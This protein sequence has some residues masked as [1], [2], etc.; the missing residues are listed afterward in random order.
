[1][2]DHSAEFRRCL[3]DLDIEGMRRLWRHTSSHLPQPKNDADA[4][5]ALH[6]ARTQAK[7]V[8]FKLRAYSH[9]W[10]TERGLPSQLPDNLRPKAERM[11]PV[12]VDAVGIS[13]NAKSELLLPIVPHIRAA[14]ENVVLDAYA[15]GDKDPSI[16]K[17][18]MNEAK[19]STVRKLVGIN[20]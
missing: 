10:L 18:R 2:I 6:L 8:P 12:V 16:I 14:M 11:Y 3:V 4:L 19:Q 5:A 17:A 9:R 13:V 1:M 15:N 20:L 7:S